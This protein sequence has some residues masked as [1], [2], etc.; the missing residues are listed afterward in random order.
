MTDANLAD[1]EIGRT[2]DGACDM[3]HKPEHIVDLDIGAIV[4]ARVR[5]GAAGDVKET[6][7]RT[8]IGDA[9]ASC[10]RLENL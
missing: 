7:V 4:D 6:D 1:G 5:P 9:N 10:R 8:V 3:L 2:K